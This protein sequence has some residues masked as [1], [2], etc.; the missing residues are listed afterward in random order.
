MSPSV[1]FFVCGTPSNHDGFQIVE[2]GPQKLPGAPRSYLDRPPGD[3]PTSYRVEA[4][5]IGARRY[6]QYARVLRINPYDSDANRGAYV[7]VGCVAGERLPMHTIAN[8][9]DAVSEIYGQVTSLLSPERKF[10]PGFKLA[11]YGY[12]GTPLDERLTHQCSPLLLAD[13]VMQGLTA[14][15]SIDWQ[16]SKPL[17]LAP[18]E[19]LGADVKRYR[20]YTA[21]GAL[22]E[23]LALDERRAEINAGVQQTLA[24]ARVAGDLQAE[25]AAFHDLVA[26]RLGRLVERASE[27]Q[28]LGDEIERVAEQ[29]AQLYASNAGGPITS[30]SRTYDPRR[31][32]GTRF[33]TRASQGQ[34]AGAHARTPGYA[35]GSHHVRRRRHGLFGL[36]RKVGPMAYTLV[37]FAVAAL[38]II[39]LTMALQPDS[40]L[41]TPEAEAVQPP[42]ASGPDSVPDQQAAT[43]PPA[44]SDIVS[45]RA[46]LDN[47]ADD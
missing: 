32:D 15:G 3:A 17:A 13:I 45:E 6:L 2:L 33:M 27:L 25:W 5:P 46:A 10:P 26:D 19:V 37:G 12:S 18:A 1:G 24:A 34:M 38:A 9:I 22:G 30:T 14:E 36:A 21:E 35:R 23:L 20:L 44:V 4:V 11:Q 28:R 31:D 42:L 41:D 39:A 16:R 29:S 7:A 40:V 43:E 47:P 8:C